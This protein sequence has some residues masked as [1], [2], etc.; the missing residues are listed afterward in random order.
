[1][2][3]LLLCVRRPGCGPQNGALWG[4]RPCWQAFYLFRRRLDVWHRSL[5]CNSSHKVYIGAECWQAH[6]N[7]SHADLLWSRLLCSHRFSRVRLC[8][9]GCSFCICLLSQRR[10]WYELLRRHEIAGWLLFLWLICYL[11]CQLYAMLLLLTLLSLRLSLCS[12]LG[13][14]VLRTRVW[15]RDRLRHGLVRRRLGSS[16]PALAGHIEPFG[17]QHVRLGLDD[18]ARLPQALPPTSEITLSNENP[19]EREWAATRC[20]MGGGCA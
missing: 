1:M 20:G 4:W 16:R 3:R 17:R 14:R 2:Q 18:A 19:A 13:Y 12:L 7:W 15:L 5:H 10:L 9:W 6:L 8:L 11:G